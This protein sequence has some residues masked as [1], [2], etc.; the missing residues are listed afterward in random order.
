MNP[1]C[2][3]L[4]ADAYDA[5]LFTN[6]LLLN[7]EINFRKLLLQVKDSVMLE[8]YNRLDLL[9]REIEAWQQ[10]NASESAERL[11]AAEAEAE[12]LEKELVVG[13]KE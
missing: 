6:G 12:Q 2:D 10:E 4:I 3:S 13:C 8:K 11:A 1:R 9:R 5:K 7:S